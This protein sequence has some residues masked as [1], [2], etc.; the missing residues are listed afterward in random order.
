MSS[1][2]I[3]KAQPS[4][5][6]EIHSLLMELSVYE[7]IE[8]L[9]ESTPSS[10]HRA[11]FGESPSAEALVAEHENSVVAT[12]IY[13]QNYST[14]MGRPGIYLED[15]YVKPNYRG[16]GIGTNLLIELAGIAVARGCGRMDWT[17]LDW[18]ASAI[19]FY[20]KLGAT[21]L[22]D[23]RIVRLSGQEIQTLADQ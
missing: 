19:D 7:K 2:T 13:F 12:A 3:R 1:A 17:V 20:R 15:I 8:H 23:W 10:T 22:P 5:V 11:L 6:D 14:F 21:I 18:N 4:D 9:V 16:R